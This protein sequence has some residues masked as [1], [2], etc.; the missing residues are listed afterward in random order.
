MYI[1]SYKVAKMCRKVIDFAK[2]LK[3]YDNELL[4]GTNQSSNLRRFHASKG[5]DSVK[6]RRGISNAEAM[7][8]CKLRHRECKNGSLPTYPTQW[9]LLNHLP[10]KQ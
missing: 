4:F 7:A 6:G 8:L 1:K 2:L 3:S 5:A 10:I 9:F